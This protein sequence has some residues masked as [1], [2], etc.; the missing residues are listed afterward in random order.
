[1]LFGPHQ[2]QAPS[3]IQKL[4][5]SWLQGSGECDGNGSKETLP[6]PTAASDHLVPPMGLRK[7]TR[8]S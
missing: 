2:L 6:N 8:S 5:P 3:W 4:E 7:T 1:M